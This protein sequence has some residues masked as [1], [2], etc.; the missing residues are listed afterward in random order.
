MRVTF[1]GEYLPCHLT[2]KDIGMQREH[3]TTLNWVS[4]KDHALNLNLVLPK[5]FRK[6]G[7][8]PG[9]LGMGNKIEAKQK[10]KGSRA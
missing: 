10:Q 3:S 4:C 2:D 9:F 7:R 6:D 8:E 1:W 5:A